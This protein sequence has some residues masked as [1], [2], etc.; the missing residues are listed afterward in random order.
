MKGI[1]EI[2]FNAEKLKELRKKYG[3]TQK[4]LADK[5]GN[6]QEMISKWENGKHSIGKA[7]QKVLNFFFSN[8]EKK[9]KKFCDKIW[10]HIFAL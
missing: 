3:L 10:F 5:L 4:Q 9:N 1:E 8:L 6:E 7:Y 2:E